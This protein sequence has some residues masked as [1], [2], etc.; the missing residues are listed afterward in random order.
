MTGSEQTDDHEVGC[1]R[2]LATT[3]LH[4]NLLSYD[5]YSDRPDPTVGLSRVASLIDQ[6]RAEA[7]KTRASTVLVDNGDSL[8]GTP[9][10]ELPT[11]IGD[12][13]QAAVP[14]AFDLL[15][16]DAIGLGNHDFDFGIDVL[17]QTVA[18]MDCS[19]ICS[20]VRAL[21]PELSLP[22]STTT[23]I[24][25][26][27]HLGTGTCPIRLGL[28]SVLPPHTMKWGAYQLRDKV[29]IDQMVTSAQRTAASLRDAG[30]DLVIALAHTGLDPHDG[31]DDAENALKPLST[32]TELD[33]IVAGHTHLTLPDGRHTFAKPIV[34]PGAHGSHLG[35]I[36]LFLTH[37]A[38][39]GWQITDHSVDLKPIIKRGPDGTVQPQSPEQQ[40]LTEALAPQHERTRRRMAQPVGGTAQSLHSFFSFVTEDRALSLAAWAQAAAVR[41]LLQNTVAANLPLLSACAPGKFGARSGP[42]NYTDVPEGPMYMRHVVDIQPFPNELRAVVVDGAQLRDWLEMSAGL[43]NTIRP[44]KGDQPLIDEDRAGHNFDVIFGLEYDIDVSVPPRFSSNGTLC[45]PQSSR[46]RNLCWQGAPVRDSQHFAIAVN[47]FRIGGG[48]NFAVPQTATRLP[49]PSVRVRDAICDYVAGRLPRDPLEDAPYPWRLRQMPQTQVE[50]FTGP[51]A[52]AHLHEL[53]PATHRVAGLT[54]DGFLKVVVSL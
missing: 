30:C 11:R 44:G 37:S 23:I 39:D 4:A 51:D 45:D 6:A 3:D 18:Q 32:L 53:D 20:N 26:D 8:F 38:Q 34:M 9:L 29:E 36:D 43:F 47:S 52:R 22:F 14:L 25:R 12:P 10:A 54:P 7:E 28:L 33:A 24:H 27:L 50:I 5:Y 49:L 17:S 46:I 2:I 13:T 1:L 15:G 40:T 19:V 31:E 21:D 48:G 35:I 16:Y 42:S 41:P